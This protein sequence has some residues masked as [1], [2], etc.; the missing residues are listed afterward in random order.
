MFAN[1][2]KYW[3]RYGSAKTDICKIINRGD[4]VDGELGPEY[5]NLVMSVTVCGYR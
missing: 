3:Y 1:F 2:V 4:V 5:S